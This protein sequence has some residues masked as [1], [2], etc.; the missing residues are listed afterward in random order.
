MWYEHPK[1]L[2]ILATEPQKAGLQAFAEWRGK[3]TLGMLEHEP[4]AT[5]LEEVAIKQAKREEA[6]AGK[7]A[8]LKWVSWLHEGLATGVGRQQK[9]SKVA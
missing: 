8:T 7:A 9:V 3:F 4:A 5:L 6:A 2:Q 1:P